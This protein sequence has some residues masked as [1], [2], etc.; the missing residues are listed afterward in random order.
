[1]QSTMEP[2]FLTTVGEGGG[3][4]QSMYDAIAYG[5]TKNHIF[6]AAAGNSSSNNDSSAHYPVQLQFG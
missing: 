1:M 2:P 6:V 3:Y 4:S 5:Q